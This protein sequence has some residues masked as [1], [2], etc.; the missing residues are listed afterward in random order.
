MAKVLLSCLLFIIFINVVFLYQN[1]IKFSAVSVIAF[2]LLL[3]LLVYLILNTYLI[4]KVKFDSKLELTNFL[5]YTTTFFVFY[6]LSNNYSFVTELRLSFLFVQSLFVILYI[7][8]GEKIV[9]FF[10]Y[11]PNILSGYCLFSFLFSFSVLNQQKQV[12]VDTIVLFCIS[13]LL[14]LI[15]KSL[16]AIYVAISILLVKYIRNFFVLAVVLIT[17]ILTGIVLLPNS[18]FDRVNWMIVGISVFFDNLFFGVGLGNF[19]FLYPFYINKLRL[20]TTIST[21]FVHNYFIHMLSETGIIWLVLF[22]FF[23]CLALSKYKKTEKQIFVLPIIGI[24]LQNIFDYNLV[25]P[26]NSILFYIFLS[27]V[28]PN[29]NNL[30]N[31]DFKN[32]SQIY[33]ITTF[34]LFL[35]SLIFMLRIERITVLLDNISGKSVNEVV[36]LNTD[37]WYI[38]RKLGIKFV[39]NNEIEK[40]QQMFIKTL[41]YNPY[42]A[43]SY[44]FISLLNF[45]F[46]KKSIAYKFLLKAVKYNPKGKYIDLLKNQIL[47]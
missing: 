25:I 23:I 37:C 26:Q 40:A 17:E 10:V 18:F 32:F 2:V 20:H 16:T 22:L 45:K 12:S 35:F 36:K 41:H 14:M 8:F 27:C 42:D 7:F 11:N 28:F 6:L 4:S 13:I 31:N 15:T 19:K 46:G 34:L 5:L 9:Y 43:E 24:L 21:I 47:R 29:S 33:K 38:Y 3:I 1:N 39:E 44:F 30:N